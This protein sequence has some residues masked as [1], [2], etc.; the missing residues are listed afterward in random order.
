MGRFAVWLAKNA[1][2]AIALIIAVVVAVLGLSSVGTNSDVVA[3]ATL[4]VLGLLA[5]SILRD[6]VRSAPVEAEV[7][8]ASAIL[9]ALPDRLDRMAEFEQLVARTRLALDES[10]AVQ[11]LSGSEVG[12]A[13]V[14]SRR[15]TDRWIYKGGTGTYIRA[16]TL[17]ECVSLARQDRRGL[18]VRLE[19]IDPSN[20]EVCEAYARFRRA[21]A[22]GANGTE[23]WTLERTRKE[24]YATI[25][26]ACWHRQ[27][28][29][30]L[31]IEIGLASTM[32]MFRW[33]L[34]NSCVIITSENPTAPALRVERGGFYYDWC[35]AEL[36]NSLDQV[37][38]VP[39]GQARATEL[40]DEPTVEEVRRLFQGLGL[41]L[42][43]SFTDRDVAEIT[44]KALR[45]VDPYAV[46]P[47]DP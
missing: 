31:D 1:D 38:R 5:A 7:R 35:A 25:L 44:R 22:E 41:G 33:D 24:S 4:L 13:L 11:I 46:A 9:N 23:P 40:S 27:R 39:I 12:A 6:R 3:S 21:G 43:R 45:A 34:S 17:P 47:R 18:T 42:P 2:A 20:E 15:S 26:A 8:H 37:R 10:A 30:L 29:R 16:V 19:I 14:A 28:F 32:T 36:L